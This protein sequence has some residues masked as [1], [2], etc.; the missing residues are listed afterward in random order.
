LLTVWSLLNSV[1]SLRLTEILLFFNILYD[2]S[3][4]RFEGF[5]NTLS[6][7]GTGLKELHP[8]LVGRLL[9]FFAGDYF[10]VV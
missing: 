7:F 5:F 8:I 9:T 6:S 4:N 3:S 1:L 10:L 2:L